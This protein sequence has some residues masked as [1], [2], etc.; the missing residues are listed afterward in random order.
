MCATPKPLVYHRPAGPGNHGGLAYVAQ[1]FTSGL[2]ELAAHAEARPKAQP[3]GSGQTP[4]AALDRAGLK[5]CAT[6]NPT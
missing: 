5:A 6:Y 2:P 3:A 1:A 4:C